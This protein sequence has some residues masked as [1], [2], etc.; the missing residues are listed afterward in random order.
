[1][2]DEAAQFVWEQVERFL[3]GDAARG[4]DTGKAAD[5]DTLL[6][7]VRAQG[8]GQLAHLAEDAFRLVA[9]MCLLGPDAACAPPV[10]VRKPLI[11]LARRLEPDESQRLTRAMEFAIPYGCGW[12]RQLCPHGDAWE[13]R[14]PNAVRALGRALEHP[15]AQARLWLEQHVVNYPPN[16]A[17]DIADAQMLAMHLLHP[18]HLQQQEAL[19]ITYGEAEALV[20]ST[21]RRPASVPAGAKHVVTAVEKTH[22]VGPRKTFSI[23]AE[24]P[25]ILTVH[26]TE[27]R[28]TVNH[29]GRRLQLQDEQTA[30]TAEPAA[31]AVWACACGNKRCATRHRLASWNPCLVNLWSYIASAVKGLP[32][33]H[34]NAFIQGMYFPLLTY[35]V[36]GVARLR[37]VSVEYKVCQECATEYEGDQCV[38]CAA[39]P[40]TRTRRRTY[41]RLVCV[42]TDPAS[43]ERAERLRCAN[44]ACGNVYAL[45]EGWET[46][47]QVRTAKV[48]QRRPERLTDMLRDQEI[49]ARGL[50][51][52]L[53]ARLATLDCPLCQTSAPRRATIVWARRFA[54]RVDQDF[55][56]LHCEEAQQKLWRDP[57]QGDEERL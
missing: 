57:N 33:L 48:W 40:E 30:Y 35:G 38:A 16:Q 34:T 14:W 41:P 43:Y 31:L 54:R 8:Q 56:A 29:G 17:H 10:A 55:R 7:V 49:D 44:T 27:A 23:N 11:D 13:Q 22:L 51:Q 9:A 1:M 32:Q 47:E 53:A 42:G 4:F 52:T 50:Q 12:R 36:E 45:P 37:L 3:R 18:L 19:R 15:V 26:D 25:M 20:E 46:W 6:H 39:A 2:T 21:Q 5:F 24:T 28:I